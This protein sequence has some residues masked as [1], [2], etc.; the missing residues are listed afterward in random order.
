MSRNSLRLPDYFGHILQAIERIQRYT[1]G[2][3]EAGFLR[4]EMTQDAVIRNFEVIG[5][6][7]AT[8]TLITFKP[9]PEIFRDTTE[10]KSDRIAAAEASR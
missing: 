1:D 7:N 4:S 8:G 10:F 9:D 6:A 2:M 5:K 3:D